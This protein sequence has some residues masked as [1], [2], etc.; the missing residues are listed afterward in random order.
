M[1]LTL[2]G[3]W[4]TGMSQAPPPGVFHPLPA[5]SREPP[6]LA[7]PCSRFPAGTVEP[8]RAANGALLAVGPV[9]VFSN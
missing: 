2:Q 8:P 6:E 9:V 3:H 7:L 1:A 5:Q 4:D